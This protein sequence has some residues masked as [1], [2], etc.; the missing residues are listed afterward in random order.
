M[1]KPHFISNDGVTPLDLTLDSGHDDVCQLL[2]SIE[3]D[4]RTSQQLE[5]EQ[6][7]MFQESS[8]PAP[9]TTQDILQ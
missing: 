9:S 4:H 3:S 5:H 7:E 6:P 2:T 1:P 8:N